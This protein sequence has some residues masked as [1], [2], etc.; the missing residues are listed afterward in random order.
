MPKGTA[1]GKQMAH[2]KRTR[3]GV[4]VLIAASFAMTSCAST[5]LPKDS[6]DINQSKRR[7]IVGY[8]A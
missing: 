2:S 5:S 4:L 7:T 6:N 8:L 1:N 3:I